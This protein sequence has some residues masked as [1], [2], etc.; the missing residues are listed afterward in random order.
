MCLGVC[1]HGGADVVSLAVHDDDHALLLSIFDRL[2]QS[3]HSLP[4]VQL[5]VSSLWLDCRHDVADFIDD[6]LVVL[7]D[8]LCSSVE[9]VAVLLEFF[10]LDVLWDVIQ[11]GIQADYAWVLHLCYLFN[12]FFHRLV[13]PSILN[14]LYAF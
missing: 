9:G 10:I 6:G 8:S 7:E 3:P 14:L 5:I 11:Q 2:A 1:L 12:Q 13:P 4:A